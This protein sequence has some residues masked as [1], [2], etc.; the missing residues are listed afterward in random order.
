MIDTTPATNTKTDDDQNNSSDQENISSS[1]RHTEILSLFGENLKTIADKRESTAPSSETNQVSYLQTL[2][3]KLTPLLISAG[4]VKGTTLTFG[5]RLLNRG[6]LAG[7]SFAPDG[8]SVDLRK[9]VFW[10]WT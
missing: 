7:V 8:R 10:S 2:S 3:E 1:P 4:L 9:E 6:I 5:R